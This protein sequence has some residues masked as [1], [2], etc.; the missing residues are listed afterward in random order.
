MSTRLI[1]IL[2]SDFL[3]T[4]TM[5]LECSYLINWL[6]HLYSSTP[7]NPTPPPPHHSSTH[8]WGRTWS[9]TWWHQRWS[10][11][12]YSGWGWRACRRP[13]S[14]GRWWPGTTGKCWSPCACACW[15][16]A[17]RWSA[18]FQTRWGRRW[19]SRAGSSECG[20]HLVQRRECL[21]DC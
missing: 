4:V 21:F 19:A 7:T 20:R 5:A 6:I 10:P 17:L 16:S 18:G 12:G 9:C 13:P 2:P 11:G 8:P 15:R 3:I 1:I 14:S